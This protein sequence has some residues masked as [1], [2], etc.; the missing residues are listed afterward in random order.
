M[1]RQRI[2]YPWH[3]E[4]AQIWKGPAS[5]QQSLLKQVLEGAPRGNVAATAGIGSRA[6]D[7]H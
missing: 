2:Q 5:M 3:T 4:E 7:E 6:Q 1:G